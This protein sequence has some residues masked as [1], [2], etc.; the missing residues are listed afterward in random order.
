M[1]RQGD[2]DQGYRGVSLRDAIRQANRVAFSVMGDGK[3]LASMTYEQVTMTV[4]DTAGSVTANATWRKQIEGLFTDFGEK[5]GDPVQPGDRRLRVEARWFEGR[6]PTIQDRLT[7][8]EGLWEIK[9][10][11]RE[12]TGSLVFFHLRRP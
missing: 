11:K 1:A 2:Q 8:D 5:D 3:V 12:T 9:S 6:T 7:D 4:D 10:V